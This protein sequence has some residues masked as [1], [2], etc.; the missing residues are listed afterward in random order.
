M[1]NIIVASAALAMFLPFAAACDSGT[2]GPAIATPRPLGDGEVLGKVDRTA[3]GAAGDILT[4]VG[5]SC[6]NGKLIVRMREQTVTGAM[7]C[8]DLPP[9]AA[10]DRV[11][12]K[13]V[14]L[15]YN[16]GK[17]TIT[18]VNG[19]SVEA[20]ASDVALTETDATPGS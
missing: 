11:L 8:N 16:A 14:T 5:L 12:S 3:D 9:Q 18:T 17:V 1:R 20:P 4:L 13:Q 15:V 10:I 6:D 19:E 2:S 7:D